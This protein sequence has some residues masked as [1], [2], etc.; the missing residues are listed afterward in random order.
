MK[1]NRIK[2]KIIINKLFK[3][4]NFIKHYLMKMN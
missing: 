1:K 3:P 4:K 2:V